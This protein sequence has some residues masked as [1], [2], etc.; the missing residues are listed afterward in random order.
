MI[1]SDSSSDP[2]I[3]LLISFPGPLG[4]DSQAKGKR[5]CSNAA[6]TSKPP[7]PVS[8]GFKGMLK[9]LS[10]TVWKVKKGLGCI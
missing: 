2:I 1:E 3:F 5:S 7:R 4:M 9:R 6:Q 10:D 8:L